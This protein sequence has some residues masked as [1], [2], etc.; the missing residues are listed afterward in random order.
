MLAPDQVES[1]SLGGWFRLRPLRAPEPL[2]DLGVVDI[3]PFGVAGV[4]GGGGGIESPGIVDDDDRE[5]AEEPE[6]GTAGA[7]AGGDDD[8]RV[9]LVAP[10]KGKGG[11]VSTGSDGSSFVSSSSCAAPTWIS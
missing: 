1:V 10:S 3:P 2:R 8:C 4:E 9:R 7:W 5:A 11:P 6:V